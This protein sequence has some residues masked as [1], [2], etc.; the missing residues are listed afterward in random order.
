MSRRNVDTVQKI[1]IVPHKWIDGRVA[2]RSSRGSIHERNDHKRKLWRLRRRRLLPPKLVAS[3]DHKIHHHNVCTTV[4]CVLC[5]IH[6]FVY[7]PSLP[8]CS[9]KSSF[10]KAPP[11]VAQSKM[12]LFDSAP[13]AQ[14]QVRI[15]LNVALRYT[16]WKI[17]SVWGFLV[18]E[19]CTHEMVGIAQ[20]QL[21]KWTPIMW[22][23]WYFK[24]LASHMKLGQIVL[25]PTNN[26]HP[27][28]GSN[29][30]L[31]TLIEERPI[32]PQNHLMRQRRNLL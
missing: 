30:K 28:L 3:A 9:V 29:K 14:L 11:L 18:V 4:Y 5:Y 1:T 20:D 15:T 8:S 16:P 26:Q 6:L 2:P 25:N 32:N 13:E 10:A 12:R 27:W 24:E 7:L 21:C 31:H 23:C 17:Q 22:A 19:K